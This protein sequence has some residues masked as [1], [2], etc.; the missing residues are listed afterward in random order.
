MGTI[1]LVEPNGWN[2][3]ISRNVFDFAL[4]FFVQTSDGDVKVFIF[5]FPYH[6]APSSTKMEADETENG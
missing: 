3:L 1:H 6:L 2:T 5:R 4:H